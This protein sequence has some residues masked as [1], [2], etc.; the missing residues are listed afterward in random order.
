MDS[1]FGR[2]LHWTVLVM[3]LLCVIDASCQERELWESAIEDQCLDV[4][5]DWKLGHSTFHNSVLE[6]A[7]K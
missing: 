3:G 6:I 1:L 2:A 4:A 7:P 5:S